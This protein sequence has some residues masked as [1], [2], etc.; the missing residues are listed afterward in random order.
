MTTRFRF[1]IG[2]RVPSKQLGRRL[3]TRIPLVE[4][5]F[6]KVYMDPNSGCWI[7]YGAWNSAGY[8]MIQREDAQRRK[9]LVHRKVWELAHGP[10]PAGLEACHKCDTPSC[11][12]P[13]H[14]FLASHRENIRDAAD[15]GKFPR[16]SLGLPRGVRP[17]PGSKTFSARRYQKHIGCFATVAL[18][19]EA[20]ERAGV[21]NGK[22]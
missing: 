17:A 16:G 1:S 8:G 15:K 22:P 20:W 5:I 12:N 21:R 3:Y 4:R 18:A 9:V 14:I 7:F 10:I 19:V 13:D 6:D 2:E 11:C